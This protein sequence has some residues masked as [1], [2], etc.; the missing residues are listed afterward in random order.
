M[1]KMQKHMKNS[2]LPQN[3]CRDITGKVRHTNERWKVHDC[4]ECV[5][6]YV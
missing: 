6:K 3:K 1:K 4:K 5:C 2:V